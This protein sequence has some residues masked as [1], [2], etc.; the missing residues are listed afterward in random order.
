MLRRSLNS[1]VLAT[2]THRKLERVFDGIDTQVRTQMINNYR[3]KMVQRELYM[4]ET[5][6]EEGI[7]KIE[8]EYCSNQKCT[9][10]LFS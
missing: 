8:K 5:L 3:I 2:I 6:H 7:G 9:C 4:Q 10:T 1:A